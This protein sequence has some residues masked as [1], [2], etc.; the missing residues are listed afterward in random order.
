[1][2]KYIEKENLPRYGSPKHKI[3]DMIWE[4]I[5]MEKSGWEILF[6]DLMIN[7]SCSR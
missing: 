2:N 6:L 4:E 5:I 1:M 7:I 3:I